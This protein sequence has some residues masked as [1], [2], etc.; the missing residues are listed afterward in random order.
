MR[1]NYV[2]DNLGLGLWFDTDNINCVIEGNRCINNLYTGIQYEISYAGLIRN[3]VVH[4]TFVAN[5]PSGQV[6]NVP[7]S[8]GAY[9]QSAI[10]VAASPN[11][12]V[13]GN[14][15]RSGYQGGG[16][17]IEV[18]QQN[19][20]TGAYGPYK[21]SNINV[22]DNDIT[23]TSTAFLPVAFSCDYNQS[24]YYAKYNGVCFNNNHYHLP[25]GNY[26]GSFIYNGNYWTFTAYQNGSGQ[27]V[28]GSIDSNLNPGANCLIYPYD[29]TKGS[30]W[31]IGGGVTVTAA[32]GDTTYPLSQ[33]LAFTAGTNANAQLSQL[34]GVRGGAV[35]A[36]LYVKGTSGQ[37]VYLLVEDPNGGK[38][39]T[40]VTFN[41]SWQQ[42]MILNATM[43]AGGGNAG[44]STWSLSTI[45]NVASTN[46]PAVTFLAWQAQAN[47]GPTLNASF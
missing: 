19:R 10:V 22:H 8:N 11:T 27:D 46:L 35:S 42:A 13:Y 23:L 39:Q 29:F 3:N 36:G 4:D 47:E 45:D 6:F 20:G 33:T 28:G 26:L 30:Y 12:E 2:H 43:A 17:T 1:G 15:V 44:R 9:G 5:P 14:S 21:C 40:A 32:S 41:G 37:Q 16:G 38:T 25:V 31:T 7:A 24:I 18:L 34:F